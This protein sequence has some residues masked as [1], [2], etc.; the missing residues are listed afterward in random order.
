MNELSFAF[1]WLFVAIVCF[2]NSFAQN[3]SGSLNI[4]SLVQFEKD[5]NKYI[6][7]LSE[8]Y[9]DGKTW[10]EDKAFIEGKIKTIGSV[11]NKM[12]QSARDLADALD[13][14]SDLRSRGAKMFLYGALL[15]NVNTKDSDAKSKYET[16]NKLE[17]EV[18]GAIVFM[19]TQLK[20]I[21]KTKIEQWLKQEPRL[22][23]HARRINRIFYE[24]PYTAEENVQKI[25]EE[26]TSAFS[27]TNHNL[28]EQIINNDLGWQTIK[29]EK[30]ESVKIDSPAYADLR[31]S[32]SQNDR[33]N[34][35]KTYFS[36]LKKWQNTFGLLYS[37]RVASAL[38]L[39]KKRNFQDGIDAMWFL[40]D[41]MPPGS[42]QTP[43]KIALEDK[44]TLQR[45]IRLKQKL[46]GLKEFNY[47]DIYA[48]SPSFERKFTIDEAMNIAVQT[49]AKMGKDYQ[50]VLLNR[51]QKKWMHIAPTK[52]KRTMY[53]TF[54]AVAG[55]PS[56]FTI[57][58]FRGDNAS[59]R[60]LA[61]AAA[62]TVAFTNF[63]KDRY[64]DT[65]DDA[66]IYSNAV[67]YAGRMM[68]D[69]Y[70]F[71][72]AKSKEER[73]FY[74]LQN[75]D[76]LWNQFF[77]NT[78]YLALDA[79]VRDLI[80]QEKVVDGEQIS[81]MYLELI[82]GL[83]GKEVKIDESFAAEWILNDITF[84]SYEGQFW[85]PAIAVASLLTER[86]NQNDE[87]AKKAM[88]QVLGRSETDLTY[89]LFKSVGID[90]SS[91]APY[92]ALIRRMNRLLDALEKE[93]SNKIFI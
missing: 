19:R 41:G 2:S 87:N 70:L 60:R 54:P 11:R 66:G 77:Q 49:F 86:I 9:Q 7:D 62:L 92:D 50:D 59:S 32:N 89:H 18:E 83:Y 43:I 27:R 61:G 69:D 31:S 51:L 80:K 29:T 76:L 64:P 63:P 4:S 17:P 33:A 79:K 12:T 36:V 73:I 91:N 35:A 81:K 88:W 78:I 46:L 65:R 23:K 26:T 6:W 13:E 5:L 21:G 3:S 44:A 40:R 30:G 16:G 48:S 45:F 58:R 75:L 74:L 14:I 57:M 55:S 47:S 71:Q 85:S 67:I 10:Q 1:Y 93:L 56:S 37:S 38:K 84:A 53:G 82:R 28:H 25:L 72:N 34:V 52:D 68:H 39:A 24:M 22:Q 15:E 8:L 20:A 90:A 42:Y